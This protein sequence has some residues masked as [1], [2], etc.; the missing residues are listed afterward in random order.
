M[1]SAII[2]Y[3]ELRAIR[4]LYEFSKEVLMFIGGK[5]QPTRNSTLAHDPIIYVDRIADELAQIVHSIE[6][7]IHSRRDKSASDTGHL[8]KLTRMLE[9]ISKKSIPVLKN[10]LKIGV[11]GS[12]VPFPL[13]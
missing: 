12:A 7:K 9:S 13:I 5:P 4:E 8:A 11:T 6:H 2:E 1:T 3:S 10:V